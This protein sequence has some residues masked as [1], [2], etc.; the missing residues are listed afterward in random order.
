MK[1]SAEKIKEMRA[2]TGLSQRKF[3]EMY[4]IPVR[5]LE[6]WEAGTR[7]PPEYVLKLLERVVLIDFK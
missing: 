1:T 3:A 2:L 6:N 5:T 4:D 7:V